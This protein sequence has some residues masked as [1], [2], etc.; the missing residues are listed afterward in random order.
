[1]TGEELKALRNAL[2]LTQQELAD[3]LGVA[4]NSP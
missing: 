3:E 2:G 4:R 1:M